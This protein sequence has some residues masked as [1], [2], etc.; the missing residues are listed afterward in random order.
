MNDTII[1]IGLNVSK[2]KIEELNSLCTCEKN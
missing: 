1:F 2:E